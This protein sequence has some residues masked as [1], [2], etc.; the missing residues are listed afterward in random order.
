MISHGLGRAVDLL[1]IRTL[2]DLI[3]RRHPQTDYTSVELAGKDKLMQNNIVSGFSRPLLS[4]YDKTRAIEDDDKL[5]RN[6][7]KITLMLTKNNLLLLSA[8]ISRSDDL[9]KNSVTLQKIIGSLL[10]RRLNARQT[11]LVND[12]FSFLTTKGGF[13]RKVHD[14]FVGDSGREYNAD[15]LVAIHCNYYFTLK[16]FLG[17]MIERCSS[18]AYLIYFYVPEILCANN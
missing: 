11:Q 10:Q 8:L 12:V 14:T 4:L 17:E 2:S 13:S 16:Q 1:M 18:H 3:K 5:Y 9:Y 15:V 6:L 7:E